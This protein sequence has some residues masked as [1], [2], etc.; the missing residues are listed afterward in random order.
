MQLP[1]A[2]T[3]AQPLPPVERRTVAEDAIKSTHEHLIAG[4]K[5][6]LLR[7]AVSFHYPPGGGQDLL[8]SATERLLGSGC[9][10]HG[11]PERVRATRA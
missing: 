5:Q 7:A 8:K 9:W 6:R 4:R 1:S 3:V 2:K 11:A 10:H